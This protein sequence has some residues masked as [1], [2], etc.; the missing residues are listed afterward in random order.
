VKIT[1]TLL[2]FFMFACG[3]FAPLGPDPY[4][5]TGGPEDCAAACDNLA[6]LQ[7]PGWE[8]SSGA[9]EEY[10]TKDDESCEL[11]CSVI[12]GE[13]T[14]TLYPICTAK[15]ETCE[16]VELCFEGGP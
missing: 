13:S 9:D 6:R 3:P 4:K 12:V 10:G 16:A 5:D 11:V 2:V 7:C 8:G 15:A 14:A 1:V